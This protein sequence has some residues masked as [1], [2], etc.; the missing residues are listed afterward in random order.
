[1]H[2]EKILKMIWIILAV[3]SVS[4]GIL[5]FT[6]IHVTYF[7][8]IYF[9]FA[10]ICILHILKF[11]IHRKLKY[12]IHIL[13][14][15]VLLSFVII[16]IDIINKGKENKPVK[17]EYVL[18]LGSGLE[19]NQMTHDLKLRL[20]KTLEYLNI[21]PD[22]KIIVSGGILRGNT[23]SEAQ[24]MSEY[25]INHGIKEE[26]II[27]ED[28]A[29]NTRTNFK[30]SYQLMKKD[31]SVTVI[32]NDYHMKRSLYLGNSLDLDLYAYPCSSDYYTTFHSYVREY[33]AYIKDTIL[34]GIKHV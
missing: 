8:Y 15:V 7:E 5:L 28:K 10:G 18:V 34:G 26:N 14:T 11:K 13:V 6:S 19:N 1:M 12:I 24:V 9:V 21:Y 30:Y 16:E 31:K 3:L 22:T 25:L 27:L 32:T 33:F 23:I 29:V 20:D 17:T 4:Y 2:K